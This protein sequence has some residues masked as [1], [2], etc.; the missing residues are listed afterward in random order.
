M[1]AGALLHLVG[2]G[3]ECEAFTRID[4][5]P[6]LGRV[7]QTLWKFVGLCQRLNGI[8]TGVSG[9]SLR[10]VLQASE[11]V[12]QRPGGQGKGKIGQHEI[13]FITSREQH[14]LHQRPHP[15]SAK[16]ALFPLFDMMVEVSRR[17]CDK[18]P[19]LASGSALEKLDWLFEA[20]QPPPD[21]TSPSCPTVPGASA[22]RG[23]HAP[24][25]SSH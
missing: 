8:R 18:D 24:T 1:M 25:R 23:S 12:V 20:I 3:E 15:A 9:A 6:E 10:R 13:D 17:C 7:L 11:D 22:S 16:M 14:R 5:P 4:F 19:A 21:G 2:R